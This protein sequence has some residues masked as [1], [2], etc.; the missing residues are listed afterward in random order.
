MF[1]LS[2]GT[3]V[4]IEDENLAATIGIAACGAVIVFAIIIAICRRMRN[5]TSQSP[6]SE[7]SSKEDGPQEEFEEVSSVSGSNRSSGGKHAR[8]GQKNSIGKTSYSTPPYSTG[9]LSAEER[10]RLLVSANPNNELFIQKPEGSIVSGMQP[11]FIPAGQ[12]YWPVQHVGHQM[13]Q[14]V[15][16]I[17]AQSPISIQQLP[18]P[19]LNYMIQQTQLSHH[20]N[21]QQQHMPV[22]YEHSLSGGSYE[23]V[24]SGPDG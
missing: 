12:G 17:H 2:L 4:P 18:Q 3:E 9:T 6:S 11:T 19:A 1:L 23:Y 8:S 16:M 14:P 10:E 13:V 7:K 5:T 24:T 20:N 15:Q 21:R 22:P